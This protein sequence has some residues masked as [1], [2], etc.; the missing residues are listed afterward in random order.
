MRNSYRI[1]TD[2][3]CGYEVQVKKWWFP[4]CW[5]QCGEG[6]DGTNTHSSIE[7]AEKYAKEYA[8]GKLVVKNLGKLP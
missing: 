8:A 1:V 7:D 5:V 6:T 4:F 3:Y 2:T